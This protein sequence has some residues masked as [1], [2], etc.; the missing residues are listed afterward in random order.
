MNAYII[1]TMVMITA[2]FGFCCF[3]LGI[4]TQAWKGKEP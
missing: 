3:D 2:C 4:H 1:I